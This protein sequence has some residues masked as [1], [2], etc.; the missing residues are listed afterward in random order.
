LKDK[1]RA[2]DPKVGGPK[3]LE[4]AES[5]SRTRP[6]FPGIETHGARAAREGHVRTPIHG[7]AHLPFDG[8][9]GICDTITFFYPE[10]KLGT[11]VKFP[12]CHLNIRFGRYV[13]RI[14]T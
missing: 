5:G 4:T 9:L 1:K 3:S 10:V 13:E 12:G 14:G 8:A 6:A 2:A 11:K 7:H